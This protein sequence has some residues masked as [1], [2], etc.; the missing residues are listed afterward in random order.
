MLLDKIQPSQ[1]SDN[2]VDT[3]KEVNND[4]FVTDGSSEFKT[5]GSSKKSLPEKTLS[6]RKS[7]IEEFIE[8]N[9]VLKLMKKY[10][11]RLDEEE[12]ET[13]M[14][15]NVGVGISNSQDLLGKGSFGTV[16]DA[17][18]T[19]LGNVDQDKEENNIKYAVKVPTQR[20]DN[21]GLEDI[22]KSK[23]LIK[24]MLNFTRRTCL[25][26]AANS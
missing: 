12:T 8:N 15:L 9:Q 2:L 16:Y 4:I 24:K 18:V 20:I 10:N 13:D 5:V 3:D 19:Q 25:R 14:C 1:T 11:P 21:D 17:E 26:Y 22:E 23:L 7:N 6:N